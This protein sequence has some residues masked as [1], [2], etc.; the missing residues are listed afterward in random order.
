MIPF[1]EVNPSQVG[2]LHIRATLI[3]MGRCLDASRPPEQTPVSAAASSPQTDGQM[4][5]RAPWPD[6]ETQ[7]TPS[8]PAGC[9]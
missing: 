8:A 4:A 2:T 1:G 3:K 5:R 7:P 9:S 6:A